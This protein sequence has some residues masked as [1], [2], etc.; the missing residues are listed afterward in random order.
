[1]LIFTCTNDDFEKVSK[2]FIDELT[3][4][5]K[6]TE[7]Q[8]LAVN[9]YDDDIEEQLEE[10]L[11]RT[12]TGFIFDREDLIGEEPYGYVSDFFE[13]CLYILREIKEHFPQV[14]IDGYVF[15]NEYGVCDCV[16]RQRVYSTPEMKDVQFIDQLQ[17]II[18]GKWVDYDDAHIPIK[19]DEIEFDVSEFNEEEFILPSY[20]SKHEDPA[21]FCICSEECKENLLEKM[22]PET[23][24]ELNEFF[25]NNK[26]N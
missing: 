22:D 15:M 7:A 26:N 2:F 19:E 6:S 14:G 13:N 1:M 10:I 25:E 20:Y 9:Y 3:E 24:L 18:C 5:I 8:T 11:E 21:N 12:E 16:M 23:A 17:C 4:S